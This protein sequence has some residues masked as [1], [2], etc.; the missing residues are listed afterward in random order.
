V[1]VPDEAARRSMLDAGL[2][3]GLAG[4]LVTL[5]AALRGGLCA[6]TTDVVC[7]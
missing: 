3:G 5:F 6:H 7:A 2:P 1:D 4:F